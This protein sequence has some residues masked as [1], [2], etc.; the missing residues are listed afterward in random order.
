MIKIA[1]TGANGRMGR[2]VIQ[3]VLKQPK[4]FKLA[5]A[6]VRK[7][8]YVQ[9]Q[10]ISDALD[11]DITGIKFEDHPE[12][13]FSKADV[14]IDFT[15]PSASLQFIAAAQ[16]AQKPILI[17]TTGFSTAQRNL[18]INASGKIPVLLAPNTSPG[19]TLM[20]K[21][22]EEAAKALGSDYDVE[23]IDIHHSSKKDAPSGTALSLADTVAKSGNHFIANDYHR[24]GERTKGAIGIYSLRAGAY[25]GE[26]DVFFAG[27]K[28]CL[29]IS[30]QSFDRS[31]YAEGA[32]K[33]AEWLKT[34]KPGLYNMRDVLGLS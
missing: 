15:E 28:E 33:G 10:D 4:R 29:K 32:L 22:L 16:Q 6:L 21:L 13:A 17:G 3:E 8:S 26:H 23:I 25:I 11:V 9:G 7:G 14:I 24:D 31:L 27:K 2:M 30:H 1:I 12:V 34:Q 19:I 18:I 20:H 5:A